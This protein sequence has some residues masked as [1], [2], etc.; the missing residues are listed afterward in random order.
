MYGEVKGCK[1]GCEFGSKGAL[2][3]GELVCSM[4]VARKVV[5]SMSIYTFFALVGKEV[6]ESY[7]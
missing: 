6:N 3:V 7:V 1:Y 2:I 4:N 5:I